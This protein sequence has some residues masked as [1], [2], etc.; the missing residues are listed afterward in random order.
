M[1]LLKLPIPLW[2]VLLL[3]S[4]SCLIT[5]FSVATPRRSFWGQENWGAGGRPIIGDERQ[6]LWRD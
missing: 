3:L 1:R 4:G 5:Y 6:G 2:V